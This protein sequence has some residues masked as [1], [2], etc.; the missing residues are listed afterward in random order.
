MATTR[1]LGGRHKA[2]ILCVSLGPRGGGADPPARSR[3]R[4][5]AADGRDGARC[6]TSTTTRRRTCSRRSSTSRSRAATSPRAALR[7]R[8]RR[9]RR[10]SARSAPTRSSSG[11]PP[12]SR[13]RRSSSCAARRPTR[14]AAFLRNENPQTIA[15]VLANVPAPDLAAN[16]MRLAPPELQAELAE[17][18]ASMEQ[19]SPEILKEIARMLKVQARRDRHAR[20]RDLGRRR[21]RSPRS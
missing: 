16:V 10:R 8:A 6:R 18:I 11:C 9:S 5:R 1:V 13:R 15:V 20:V 12:R 17:R 4:D 21:T 7:S 14:S 19:I 3:G 2:A